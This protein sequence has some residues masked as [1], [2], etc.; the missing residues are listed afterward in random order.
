MMEVTSFRFMLNQTNKPGKLEP[1]IR[2]LGMMGGG[3]CE[4]PPWK[5]TSDACKVEKFLHDKDSLHTA[6][7][8]MK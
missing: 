8:L 3:I 4:L 6:Q 7:I 2:G 5:Q 1:E